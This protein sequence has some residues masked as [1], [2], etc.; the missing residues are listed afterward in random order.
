MM[1]CTSDEKEKEESARVDTP[2]D[3]GLNRSQAIIVLISRRV[4]GGACVS[5][6]VESNRTESGTLTALD[7]PV[8]SCHWAGTGWDGSGSGL[9]IIF[10]LLL[11]GRAVIHRLLVR[12]T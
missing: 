9:T 8:S 12:L 7:A 10:R 1:N 2:R 5:K 3:D 11:L 4:G 6:L